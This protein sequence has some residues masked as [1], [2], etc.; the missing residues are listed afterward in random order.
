M[1]GEEKKAMEEENAFQE[2]LIA[3]QRDNGLRGFFPLPWAEEE[4]LWSASI[5][6]KCAQNGNHV[7][8]GGMSYVLGEAIHALDGRLLGEYYPYKLRGEHD[9]D[10]NFLDV[11]AAA[12][13]SGGQVK[14]EEADRWYAP[15]MLEQLKR[16]NED[17]RLRCRL[18]PWARYLEAASERLLK[19]CG[20]GQPKIPCTAGGQRVCC[21][22]MDEVYGLAAQYP[23]D[24]RLEDPQLCSREQRT[25]IEAIRQYQLAALAGE[26]D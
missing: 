8:Y 23:G 16:V 24:F 2:K 15:W 5:L 11:L 20:L 26:A 21:R 19:Q 10:H 22:D 3:Y 9:H 7:E 6:V 1:N 4:G 17:R 14:A 18:Y 12:V 25:C 13:R